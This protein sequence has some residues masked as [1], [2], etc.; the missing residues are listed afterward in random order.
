MIAFACSSC[1][2]SLQAK[3]ELAGKKSRCPKRGGRDRDSRR[4]G[5]ERRRRDADPV[6]R[7]AV[8]EIARRGRHA[9]G[10]FGC[11]VGSPAA[12]RQRR[13]HRTDRQVAGG[14]QRGGTELISQSQTGDTLPGPKTPNFCS[15]GMRFPPFSR[16]PNE[17]ARWGGL[18]PIES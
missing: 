14:Q 10:S 2:K 15:R 8:G 5:G 18:A 6:I 4:R 7:C 17:R 13:R 9:T 3:V 1:K 11:T 12:A 16:L